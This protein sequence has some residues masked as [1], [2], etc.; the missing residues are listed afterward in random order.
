MAE[1]RGQ[2]GLLAGNGCFKN[3]TRFKLEILSSHCFSLTVKAVQSLQ[4][5][6]VLSFPVVRFSCAQKVLKEPPTFVRYPSF[7]SIAQAEICPCGGASSASFKMSST[8]TALRHASLS[9]PFYSLSSS[10]S[11]ASTSRQ[12]LLSCP[13]ARYAGENRGKKVVMSASSGQAEL[14]ER[15]KVGEPECVWHVCSL[16]PIKPA[17]RTTF[18]VSK[19]ED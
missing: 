7:T 14:R 4:F 19:G 10:D 12:V 15:T 16:P 1:Q 3:K 17:C 11:L 9:S 8:S 5:R 13:C 2:R 6:A 18:I